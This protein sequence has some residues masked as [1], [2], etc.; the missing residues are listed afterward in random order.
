ML[1]FCRYY[2]PGLET[3]CMTLIGSPNF[4]ERSVKLDLETQIAIVTE[5][6]ELRNKL[7]EEC[8]YLYKL[9]LPADTNRKIPNWVH[10]MVFLFKKYF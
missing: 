10:V 7:H 3:P 6:N 8:R 4:G 1:L 9:G 2:P 5:N